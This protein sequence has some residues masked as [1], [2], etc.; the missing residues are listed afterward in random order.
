[1]PTKQKKNTSQQSSNITTRSKSIYKEGQNPK[2]KTKKKDI[3][4]DKNRY[5]SYSTPNRGNMTSTSKKSKTTL[6]TNIL[7]N[8]A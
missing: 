2:K 3:T 1:M 6:K 5:G 7:P 4:I 8:T